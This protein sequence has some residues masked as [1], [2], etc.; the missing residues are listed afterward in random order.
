MRTP[1]SF[2]KAAACV[3]CSASLYPVL[4]IASPIGEQFEWKPHT[5]VNDLNT[6][7]YNLDNVIKKPCR[8]AVKDCSGKKKY[9]PF[10]YVETIS[11]VEQCRSIVP[12]SSSFARNLKPDEEI[13]PEECGLMDH[14]TPLGREVSAGGGD[15]HLYWAS[16]PE[17]EVLERQSMR[18]KNNEGGCDEPEFNPVNDP[19]PRPTGLDKNVVKDVA[20]GHNVPFTLLHTCLNATAEFILRTNSDDLSSLGLYEERYPSLCAAGF[21]VDSNH[22]ITEC[23]EDLRYCRDHVNQLPGTA[24]PLC[25]NCIT[26]PDNTFKPQPVVTDGGDIE[27]P[28]GGCLPNKECRS[29]LFKTAYL[30]NRQY[31]DICDCNEATRYMLESPT[32]IN[33]ELRLNSDT[34]LLETVSLDQDTADYTNEFVNTEES[35]YD[36]N[37]WDYR[38][39]V[40]GVN[41]YSQPAYNFLCMAHL[42]PCSTTDSEGNSVVGITIRNDETC[43]HLEHSGNGVTLYPLAQE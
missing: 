22:M 13:Y 10:G 33:S 32:V 42:N 16:A 8:I 39:S 4:S 20:R 28:S 21:I 14:L 35:G 26:C 31:P 34:G 12:V 19:L 38:S 11:D 7:V 30:S 1:K 27:N 41:R 6:F 25:Y 2:S 24:E 29:P 5:T 17:F 36:N 18:S 15:Y 23:S 43:Y 40:G 37:K 3:I 9:L